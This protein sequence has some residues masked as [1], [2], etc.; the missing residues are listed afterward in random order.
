[1]S[2][3]KNSLLGFFGKGSRTELSDQFTKASGVALLFCGEGLNLKLLFIKRATNPRDNWSGHLAFPGGK[4]EDSDASLL[5]AC[6]RE[7]YEEVGLRLNP[8]AL[9]GSLD[10][11]QARQR[12]HLVEFFIQ[13]FIFYLEEVPKLFACENEVAEVMWVGLEHLRDEANRADF[14][15]QRDGESMSFPG[16]RFLNGDILWGLTYM[17]VTN[18]LKK[19]EGF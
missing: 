9:I 3:T 7:L 12:G 14:V 5:D 18:L 10:D 8:S 11:I 2:K 4:K 13:P 1:M 6:L 19:L 17:M 15:Y 16:I